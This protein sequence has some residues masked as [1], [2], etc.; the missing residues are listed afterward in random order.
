MEEA[1]AGGEG[2]APS[3]SDFR[4][5]RSS[6]LEPGSLHLSDYLLGRTCRLLNESLLVTDKGKEF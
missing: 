2:E 1:S 5:P 4:W 6:I 3:W